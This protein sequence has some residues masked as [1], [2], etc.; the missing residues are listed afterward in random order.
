MRV[1][2]FFCLGV[3]MLGLFKRRRRASTA[4]GPISPRG[5]KSPRVEQKEKEEESLQLIEEQKKL[6]PKELFLLESEPI[7]FSIN[8]ILD[9]FFVIKS[10]LFLSSS[11]FLLSFL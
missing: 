5:A 4:T 7:E 1:F 6:S 3:E 2:L 8:N 9:L 10:G 11:P